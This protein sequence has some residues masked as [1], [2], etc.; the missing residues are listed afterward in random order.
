MSQVSMHSFCVHLRFLLLYFLTALL[1]CVAFILKLSSPSFRQTDG[2]ATRVPCE[3][4]I[5][6]LAALYNPPNGYPVLRLRL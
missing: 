1:R 5:L 6:E 3:S 2:F 4:V